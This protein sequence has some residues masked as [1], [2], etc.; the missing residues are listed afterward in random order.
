MRDA[1][2][3]GAG[4][5][6]STVA[7]SLRKHM[8]NVLVIDSHEPMSGT[9]P[10]GGHLKPS[11]FGGMK[12]EEYEPAM[13]LLDDIW[14]LH[15][16]EFTV[17]SGI[18]T[19]KAIVFRV[20]TDKVVTQHIRGQV[21]ELD[22]LTGKVAVTFRS[23]LKGI[24]TEECK[25]LVLA[26]GAWADQLTGVDCTSKQGV[27]F[28]LPGRLPKPFIAPW[29]PYKQ[30]VVHQQTSNTIWAGDG[31][32]IIPSNWNDK[33]TENC[34]QRCQTALG[35]RLVNYRSNAP[36]PIETR[37]GLRAYCEHPKNEPCLFKQ[38]ATNVFVAT[39]A[40]KSGTI[41]AGWVTRKILQHV[42]AI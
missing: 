33:R 3:V 15:T 27:S 23:G 26:T 1:I 18:A 34:L 10:S 25:L 42:G 17:F 40:G 13:E 39:G 29:A 4:I 37:V 36:A 24:Q 21:L 35:R 2:V 5:I 38:L 19:S 16:E 8:N 7:E 32:A 31:S 28:R 14:G 22:N 41:S 9:K 20:D 30:V 11:W 6:G 12:K